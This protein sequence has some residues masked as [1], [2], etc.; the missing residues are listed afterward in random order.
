MTEDD[1]D[2]WKTCCNKPLFYGLK[3]WR[4]QHSPNYASK[5]LKALRFVCAILGLGY[6][7]GLWHGR[8]LLGALF[9]KS[10]W[11]FLQ[12]FV[13]IEPPH[14]DLLAQPVCR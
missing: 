6:C 3:C 7:L 2:Y 8:V 13:D 4:S 14:H 12:K 10:G 5:R 11:Q 9:A 1:L